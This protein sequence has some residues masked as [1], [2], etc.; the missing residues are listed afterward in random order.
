MPLKIYYYLVIFMI[1]VGITKIYPN[2]Q[3]VIPSTIRN[4][5]KITKDTLVEW[6]I[7]GD[8]MVIL[9]FKS[10]K[11]KISDLAALGKGKSNEK[12]NAVNLKRSLYE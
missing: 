9:T 4:R 5:F 6:N 1:N 12:T 10:E 7:N 3:T 2:N 11:P 8:D